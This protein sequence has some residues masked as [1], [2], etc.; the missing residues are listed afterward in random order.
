MLDTQISDLEQRI[1]SVIAREETSATRAGRLRS[2][3]GISPVS[4]AM[5]IA[6]M[7]KRGRMTLGE[8]AAMT[9]RAPVPVLSH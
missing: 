7:T 9:G 3:P 8:A 6:D 4:A 5:L 2:I 1:E